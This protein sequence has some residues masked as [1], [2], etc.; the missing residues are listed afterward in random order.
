MGR[1]HTTAALF[2]DILRV[3]ALLRCCRAISPPRDLFF[4]WLACIVCVC[5]LMSVWVCCVCSLTW[6][7]WGPTLGR[8]SRPPSIFSLVSYE[9]LCDDS[10][11]I[12]V[13]LSFIFVLSRAVWYC[14]RAR[15]YSHEAWLIYQSTSAVST[16]SRGQLHKRSPLSVVV[17]SPVVVVVIVVILRG[18]RGCWIDAVGSFDLGLDLE[19][20]LRSSCIFSP[21]AVTA[22]APPHL[23]ALNVNRLRIALAW[24][25]RHVTCDTGIDGCGAAG[26]VSKRRGRIFQLPDRDRFPHRRE[27]QRG[28]HHPGGAFGSCVGGTGIRVPP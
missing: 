10:F 1:Q 4:H 3:A 2:C 25:A 20:P 6:R 11:A 23:T 5:V 27:H 7:T 17:D 8:P 28:A 19:H 9:R 16:C 12:L 15:G 22:A 26:R 18:R 14:S 13:A 21:A 24:T